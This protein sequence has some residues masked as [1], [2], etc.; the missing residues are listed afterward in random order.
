MTNLTGKVAVILGAAGKDNMGQ[1]IARKLA[2]AGA[3]VV[4]AGRHEEALSALAAEI[5]G[6]W[7]LCDIAKKADVEALA[8]E[9][10]KRHGRLDIGVNAT[11]WGL[12]KSLHDISEGELDQIIALQF[13]GVHYFLSA[14]IRSMPQGGSLMQISSAT[15][16]CIID[17]HAAYIGTKAGSEALIRCVANQY[18]PQGI[19]ANTV[20]PGFTDSPM[21]AASFATPGL[22][23]A[24]VK[25]YPLGRVGTS[26]DIAHAVLW[27]AD[28]ASFVSGQNIQV[29]GGLTLR[30]NPR[31]AEI[32][33]AIGAAM[34]KQA[35]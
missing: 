5:G 4:V 2:G 25:E 3:K 34:Q 32:G 33:A 16:Q 24:F 17:D 6:D 30:R 13:K 1:T 15:T 11:G 31:P 7:M 9:T 22:V 8:S 28:D 20:S 12:L 10:V 35:S 27:L 23:D 18:G 26:D 29:N 21:T 19:R 14:F